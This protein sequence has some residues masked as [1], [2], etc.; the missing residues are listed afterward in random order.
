MKRE[1]IFA[2]KKVLIVNKLF[3]NYKFTS[4][5]SEAFLIDKLS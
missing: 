5:Q 3:L 1:K 2:L 4:N